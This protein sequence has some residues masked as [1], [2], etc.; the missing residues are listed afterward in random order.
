MGK[1]AEIKTKETTSSVEDFINSLKDEKKRKD[2][3]T[4]LKLMQKATK[5][6]PK[7]WGS[8]MI[9]FGKKVYK[10]PASGRE[11]EWFK[12]GFSPRKANFSLNLVLD[13]KQHADILKKLGKHKTGM[14]CLYINKL[15]DIDLKVLEKMINTAA[16]GK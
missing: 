9:G 12:I 16:K 13:I 2:S 10:S 7:M 15:D 14:G 6:K 5:E 4:L 8:S 1:L 3:F 11:V